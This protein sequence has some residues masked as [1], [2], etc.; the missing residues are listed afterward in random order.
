MHA[1][2]SLSAQIFMKN[3]FHSVFLTRSILYLILKG[4]TAWP[5]FLLY[6]LNYL[7]KLQ[8]K[9]WWRK[10]KRVHRKREETL[11]AET[12]P[13]AVSELSSPHSRHWACFV[14][15]IPHCG[16]PNC[17]CVFVWVVTWRMTSLLYA[18]YDAYTFTVH[19]FTLSSDLKSIIWWLTIHIKS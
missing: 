18:I 12:I 15:V 6:A 8:S 13:K 10:S 4:I 9:W 5:Y 11:R 7:Q 19:F 2:L 16:S 1:K 3:D 14:H 17:A